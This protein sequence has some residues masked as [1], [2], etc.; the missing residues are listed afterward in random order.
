MKIK[1]LRGEPL[2]TPPA[3]DEASW[4]SLTE[5]DKRGIRGH[6][7]HLREH[8]VGYD[9]ARLLY[10]M[11]VIGMSDE[12]TSSDVEIMRQSLAR[13]RARAS[14]TNPSSLVTTC[15]HRRL[16][17]AFP[18]TEDE[19]AVSKHNLKWGRSE[20]AGLP[21]AENLILLG[22]IEDAEKPTPADIRTIR[23][24]LQ[25]NMDMGVLDTGLLYYMKKLAIPFTLRIQDEGTFEAILESNR[26][27]RDWLHLAET[28]HELREILGLTETPE[29]QTETPIPPLKRFSK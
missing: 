25:V 8:K 21:V 1:E 16:G 24:S 26:S 6:L 5:S 15:F 23:N 14:R 13:D 17:L 4:Y 2:L 9:M 18:P 3:R 7:R 29:K 20:G 27:R 22:E 12:I 11:H 19:M 28:H 10:H